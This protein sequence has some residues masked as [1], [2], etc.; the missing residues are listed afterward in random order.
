[1]KRFL[2]GLVAAGVVTG[3]VALAGSARRIEWEEAFGEARPGR[4][5]LLSTRFD[6]ASITKP[7]VATL[8]LLLDEDGTLPL[9]ARVGDL[10]PAAHRDLA[11][12]RWSELLRHRAGMQGW[13]SFYDPPCRSREEARDRMV[14]GE[15]LGASRRG[16]YS[17][18]DFVLYGMAVEEATGAPL[19][20]L[21]RSRVCAPLGLA[22]VEAVPGD[23]PDVA[24]S[25][26]HTGKEVELAAAQGRTIANLGPPPPG[27]PQ[28]GN[29]RFF[30][31]LLGLGTLSG[32]AGL[33]GGAD[34]V[35]R[36]AAEWLEPGKLLQEEAVAAAL[37]GGGPFAL[38]WWRRTLRNAAGRS[39]GTRAFGHTGFAGGDVWIDPEGPEGRQILV[40][41][42]HRTDPSIDMNR[43]RRRFHTLARTTLDTLPS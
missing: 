5:A 33:F 4:P 24:V 40:L 15:L 22:T 38:G 11:R 7:F 14:R 9:A 35:W 28:D 37:A 23:R 13:T 32:N 30:A 39:L 3:G 43:V 42:T 2:D 29:A 25:V 12:R 6:L 18:L 17:D 19:A 8:A 26:M 21:V 1:M 20:S 31:S 16:V 10:W 34:D 27:L 36:L 41:L